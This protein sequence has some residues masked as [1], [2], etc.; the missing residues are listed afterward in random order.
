MRKIELEL[1]GKSE[2]MREGGGVC[3][4]YD[5]VAY[6]DKVRERKILNLQFESD[7]Y[8]ACSCLL[9]DWKTLHFHQLQ[10][11]MIYHLILEPLHGRITVQI[12]NYR[13]ETETTLPENGT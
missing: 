7:L 9:Q 5:H 1:A 12:P 2:M 8:L 13:P 4:N 11:R 3:Q 10:E 6:G